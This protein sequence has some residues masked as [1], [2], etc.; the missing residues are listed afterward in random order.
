MLATL[1]LMAVEVVLRSGYTLRPV[2]GVEAGLDQAGL[3]RS[4][5]DR[6]RLGPDQVEP[7]WHQAMRLRMS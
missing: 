6:A 7:K 4:G 2:G 3:D 1:T 5:L